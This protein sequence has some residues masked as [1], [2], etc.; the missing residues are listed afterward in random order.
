MSEV[1]SAGLRRPERLEWP[2]YGDP[3]SQAG[4]WVPETMYGWQCDVLRACMEMGAR[5]AVVTPNESGKTSVV[6]P[7]LGL[8]F[9]AA[10]P[11]AQVVSTAGVERQIQEA[12]WPVLRQ[13]L[14]KYPDWRIT[15]DLKITAP[16]VE[17]LPGS[18]WEAFTTKDPEYAEGFHPRWYTSDQHPDPVYAPLMII[19]DEA[20]SFQGERGYQMV[21]TFVKR[22]S[23]DVMLMISTSGVDDGP[24]Y[25]CFH[26]NRNKPWHPHEIGWHDC[27]HLRTGFKLRERLDTIEELGDDHPFVM[28][29]VYGKFFRRGDT[30]IFDSMDL[31]DLAMRGAVTPLRGERRAALD[32]SGGGDEAVFGAAEG[33][34]VLALEGFHERDTMRLGDIFIERLGKWQVPPDKVVADE[35]GL[36]KP[37]IDYLERKLQVGI[38]RYLFN[39]PARDKRKFYNKAAEDH[40][41]LRHRVQQRAVVLPEDEVL[42]EQMR[43]RKYEIKGDGNQIALEPKKKLRDRGERSPDRLD[44]VVMLFE[45]QPEVILGEPVA[46]QDPTAVF[47]RCGRPE[48]CF[49]RPAVRGVGPFGWGGSRFER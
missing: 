31:V 40:F 9:M 26:V 41:D 37:I 46:A 14:Q 30:F 43:K 42:R 10:F 38:G 6:I 8:A 2:K 29:W 32:F 23:P 17:G 21:R 36:G 13:S 1:Q 47:S 19:I 22:C 28:S 44:V 45:D 7:V 35:G 33:N 16:S 24:F 18:T 5:E 34:R 39:G 48:D 27:P 49:R 3:V 4:L 12:L 11:G 20:K 25:D 15:D